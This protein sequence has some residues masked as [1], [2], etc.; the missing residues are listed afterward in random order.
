MHARDRLEDIV[1]T[2]KE[3][4]KN[5]IAWPLSDSPDSD[6]IKLENECQEAIKEV[7]RVRDMVSFRLCLSFF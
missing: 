1:Y 3:L 6:Q 2:E 7:D 4:E 5:P